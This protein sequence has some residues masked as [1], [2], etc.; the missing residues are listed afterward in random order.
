[1]WVGNDFELLGSTYIDLEPYF[2]KANV[3]NKLD[4]PNNDNSH[5]LSAYQGKVL[6]DKKEE[7]SN[8]KTSWQEI[9]T[10]TAYPSEQLVYESILE[11]ID[12]AR[13]LL[14]G[15]QDLDKNV[16]E[17][18]LDN[19]AEKLN[20]IPTKTSDLINDSDFIKEAD[21]IKGLEDKVDTIDM[22]NYLGIDVPNSTYI[23]KVDII[24]N[25]TTS[26]SSKVLSAQQGK[27]LQD[28]DSGSAERE[29]TGQGR[30]CRRGSCVP[31]MRCR[32]GKGRLQS[33]HLRKRSK[34]RRS[35]D[36]WNHSIQTAAGSC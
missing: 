10:N 12:K 29:E 5:A 32:T 4:Y 30:L 16:L 11:S 27:A 14:E 34:S 33:N 35:S 31:G 21:F 18:F 9:V 15:S 36:L 19:F 26:D 24:N 8:K 1:M 7:V 22:E 25:L 17:E 28:E 3:Y 20:S 13:E 2:L 23:P 6:N